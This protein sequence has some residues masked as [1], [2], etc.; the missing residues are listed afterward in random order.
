MPAGRLFEQNAILFKH[1]SEH[2]GFGELVAHF[3]DNVHA[4]LHDVGL[5]EG[6]VPESRELAGHSDLALVLVFHD[7][8]A[9]LERADDAEYAVF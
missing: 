4:A 5:P 7:I 2:R 8:A 3:P 1:G 9:I 6:G